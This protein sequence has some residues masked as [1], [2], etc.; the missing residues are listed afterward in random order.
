MH[1]RLQSAESRR[2][3]DAG[4]RGAEPEGRE[5]KANSKTRSFTKIPKSRP[6]GVNWGRTNAKQW[7]GVSVECQWSVPARIWPILPMVFLS[8][9]PLARQLPKN[10]GLSMKALRVHKWGSDDSFCRSP[11]PFARP[12][13][14]RSAG[15]RLSSCQLCLV[16][17]STLVPRPET[18]ILTE[19]M[20]KQDSGALRSSRVVT[21]VSL[22]RS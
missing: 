16:E 21:V 11:V 19:S 10:I 13:E 12:L 17:S 1:A 9:P 18:D 15:D 3:R 7:Y 14:L 4:K 5:F 22:P 6:F 20:S 8:R 2:T